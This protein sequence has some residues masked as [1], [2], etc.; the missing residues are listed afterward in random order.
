MGILVT[1]PVPDIRQHP[2][3]EETLA[4]ARS[5][6][7]GLAH[8]PKRLESRFLYDDRGSELFEQIC[9][10]PEYYLTRVEA[11]LLRQ[12]AAEIVAIT[13]APSLVE[14]GAGNG[15]KTDILLASYCQAVGGACYVPV[16]V[17]ASAL[18]KAR[19]RLLH[20]LPEVECRPIHA[21]YDEGLARS[22]SQAPVMLLFLGS[23]MGNMDRREQQRSWRVWSSQLKRGDFLLIGVD[24]NR[25]AQAL[26]AAYN[27]A[28]GVTAQFT[29]NLFVRINRELGAEIEL[30]HIEHVAHYNAQ[31]RRVEIR[32]KF[33]RPQRIDIPAL[34][35]SHCVDAGESIQ[36]EISRRFRITDL[37]Q[38]AS[39]YGFETLRV[40]REGEGRYA[41]A[42]MR[43]R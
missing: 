8:N 11:E 32:A 33:H 17:S 43:R 10:Q 21:Q 14:L 15:E 4:F 5:V 30:D 35:V 40:F 6:A 25:D 41:V 22:V 38:E 34:G 26:H 7:A 9:E 20:R 31:R 2:H 36:T 12:H 3:A 19:N 39:V 27:D 28:A 18:S 16:D 1:R 24:I 13:G 42:L 29:R 37:K 23:T